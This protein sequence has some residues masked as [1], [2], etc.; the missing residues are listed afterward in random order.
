MNKQLKEKISNNFLETLSVEFYSKLGWKLNLKNGCFTKGEY[1]VFC[2]ETAEYFNNLVFRPYLSVKHK[3]IA[4]IL[5]QIFP[6]SPTYNHVGRGQSQELAQ[7][8]GVEWQSAYL[9]EQDNYHY[10][11]YEGTDITPIVADHWQ[12]MEKV[13]FPFF[14]NFSSLERIDAFFNDRLLGKSFEEFQENLNEPIGEKKWLDFYNV[15]GANYGLVSA[16]LIKNKNI[17][18][19]IKRY[20]LLY[21]KYPVLE[22]FEKLIIHFEANF[23]PSVSPEGT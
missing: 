22:D 21:S 5:N 13:G 7:M 8:V 10:S 6:D 9:H 18:E 20:T 17:K 3:I 1:K 2:G 4:D 19:I 16:F 14:D 23:A 15:T 12:Y 11:I